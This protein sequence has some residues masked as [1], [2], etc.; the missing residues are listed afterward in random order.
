[1][2]NNVQRSRNT[3]PDYETKTPSRTRRQTE[4]EIRLRK[5]EVSS[6]S[7]EKIVREDQHHGRVVFFKAH[8]SMGNNSPKGLINQPEVDA[9]ELP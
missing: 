9:C 7:K 8:W 3:M 5:N 4:R 6:M 2:K 1:M